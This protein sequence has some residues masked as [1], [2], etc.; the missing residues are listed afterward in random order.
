MSGGRRAFL[1]MAGAALLLPLGSAAHAQSADFAPPARPMRYVR[2][3]RHGMVD[4][5]AIETERFF[6]V[7]FVPHADG[8]RIEGE[9]SAPPQV[10]GPAGLEAFLRL[11]R[12]RRETGLFP[13]TLDR[14]GRIV[15]DS[16]WADSPQLD[17]A[18]AEALHRLAASHLG[19]DDREAAR[20][21]LTGLHQAAASLVAGLPA[22]LF[23]PPAGRRDASREVA[24]PGGGTG[25]V[26]LTFTA[27]TDPATGVMR[28]AE[29]V[30]LTRLATSERRTV[31]R[32]SLSPA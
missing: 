10:S 24:L 9:E 32:W 3:L 28:E 4:G 7:A 14:A 11:E 22:D 6:T 31:E 2:A 15:G 13:L 27:S 25:T 30:V 16:S 5:A 8:Y 1:G 26:S 23:R 29:R 19:A 12:E 21:F 20:T 18:I 17:R